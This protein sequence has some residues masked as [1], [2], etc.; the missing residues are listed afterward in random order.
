MQHAIPITASPGNHTM[1][2]SLIPYVTDKIHQDLRDTAID[3]IQVV[4]AVQ[5]EP[6]ARIAAFERDQIIDYRRP[7]V[8]SVD[9]STAQLNC[10][11]S[12]N[13]VLHYASL[14]STYLKLCG[15]N[16]DIVRA[17]L[18]SPLQTA[19]FLR[20]SNLRFL[21]PVDLAIIGDVHKLNLHEGEWQGNRGPEPRIFRWKKFTSP[22]G[23]TVAMIGCQ[24]KIWGD[25][26]YHLIHA[27]RA[28]S[29][30]QC[31]IYIAKSG[32]LLK[33]LDPNT[34][35]ATGDVAFL[36]EEIIHWENPLKEATDLAT[37]VV[38]GPI[39]TVPTSLCETQEWLR[40]WS[41]KAHWV[42]C[43]VGYMAKAAAE[44]RIPFGF[45][46]VVSDN[47]HLTD[48]ENLSNEDSPSVLRKRESLYEVMNNILDTLIA[49]WTGES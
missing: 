21:G 14:V 43:E 33:H 28:G 49:R 16:P 36:D 27:L 4:G 3:C 2:E 29:G 1:G 34:W 26:S 46:H 12:R 18:P 39:V 17:T 11:P 20:E 35:I 41:T 15:R 8:L 10:F 32:S 30:V 13:L 42:D 31:V 48:G 19:E 25:A 24:E 5:R 38:D 44:L 37:R 23:K 45:L 9:S 40:Q 7:T 47:L 6:P 22:Q